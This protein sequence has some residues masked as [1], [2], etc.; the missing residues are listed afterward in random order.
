MSEIAE[1]KAN[2]EIAFTAGYFVERI[3]RHEKTDYDVKIAGVVRADYITKTILLDPWSP[4]AKADECRSRYVDR[5][6]RHIYG[7]RKNMSRY[8]RTT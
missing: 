4:F 3:R 2:Y 1:M 7:I 5:I 8:S 6:S